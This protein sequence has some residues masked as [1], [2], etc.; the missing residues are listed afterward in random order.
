MDN[1]AKKIA[2]EL[3]INE[4]QVQ[5]T[6]KLIDEGNTIPFIARYRKEITG[7]LDDEC[8]RKLNDRLEYL[9]NLELRKEEVIR[10]IEEQGKLT[11]ELKKE[12]LSDILTEVEDLYRPYKQKKRTKATIA[13]EKGLEPFAV[14]ILEQNEKNGSV[15]EIAINYINKEK[16]VENVEDAISGALDIIA[17][18]ISDNASY[19]K[20]IRRLSYVTGKI[21]S[22]AQDDTKK[23]NYEM[24]YKYEEPV[25]WIPSHRILAMNRGEKEG[26]LKVF[27]KGEFLF[28]HI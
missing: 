19:R 22:M 27:F 25:K 10:L 24:Y 20:N 1:I 15:E 3:G 5:K 26:Y 2:V 21:V 9:R 18:D 7:N 11:E 28:W 17:E 16:G 4:I 14:R 12:I 23:S 13:R 6:I 8:L